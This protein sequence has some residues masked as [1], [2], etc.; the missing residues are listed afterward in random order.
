MDLW[1][2]I[3][4]YNPVV[5]G[6]MLIFQSV[7]EMHVFVLRGSVCAQIHSAAEPGL[8]DAELVPRFDSLIRVG[9]AEAFR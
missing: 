1:K 3:F 6:S 4:L 9:G 7:I 5:S 8:R 2:T